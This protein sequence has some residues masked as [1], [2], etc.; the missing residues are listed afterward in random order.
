MRK[1]I[2]QVATFVISGIFG[3][4][5]TSLL[6]MTEVQQQI[7]AA[8]SL[9]MMVIIAILTS[10]VEKRK[11]KDGGKRVASNSKSK[12]KKRRKVRRK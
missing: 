6:T 3:S 9:G 12:S 2:E 7:L 1:A 4:T 10:I 11:A 5:W 8:V